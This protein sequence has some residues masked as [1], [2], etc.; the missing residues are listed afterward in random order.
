MIHWGGSHCIIMLDCSM[1]INGYA[2]NFNFNCSFQVSGVIFYAPHCSGAKIISS[3]TTLPHHHSNILY[4]D[5]HID[6][7]TYIIERFYDNEVEG[8]CEIGS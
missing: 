4:N 1:S 6:M 5:I 7:R 8:N 3:A 2:D